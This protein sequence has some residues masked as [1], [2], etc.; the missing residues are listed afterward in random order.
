MRKSRSNLL[1]A[2]LLILCSTTLLFSEIPSTTLESFPPLKEIYHPVSTK[3]VEAQ[4]NFDRGLTFIY[5]FNHD[6]AY[7][8][9]A[10]AAEMD[11]ELAMAYW[12]MALALGQNINTDVTLE[13][14]LKAYDLVQKAVKLA[15]LASASEQSYIQALSKRYTNDSEAD[16]VLLRFHYRD[17]MKKVAAAYPE[18]LDATTLYAESIL[19]LDPWKYWNND[20]SP[21]EGTLEVVEKLESVLSRNPEHL[22]A[23][24]YYIHA[25]EGSLHPER[26]LPSALRLETLLPAAG[27]LLHMPCHIFV[28][29]GDYR[30]AVTMSKRAIEADREYMKTQGK[31]QE[32]SGHYPVHY[33]SHNYLVLTRVYMLLEEYFNAI[34]TASQLQQFL[35]PHF[36]TMPDRIP[37]TLVSLQVYLYFH[38]WQE[39]INYKT[40]SLTPATQA[41]EHYSRSSAFAHLHDM[42]AA[43]KER[44]LM[45]AAVL[46]IE[47]EEIAGNPAKKVVGLAEI[48]LEATFAEVENRY[49]ESIEHLQKALEV[50]KEL[51]YNEPPAWHVPIAQLLGFAY[52]HEKNYIEAEKQFRNCLTTLR[53]NGRSL[54]GLWKSLV[55]QGRE[56]DAY[57][58]ERE[59][60]AALGPITPTFNP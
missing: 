4:K 3:N 32:W 19:D 27:H 16:F 47:E 31:S 59:M 10:K 22:G 6:L 1:I 40:L 17:A 37:L 58:V 45:K 56:I 46:R 53:R 25:M 42:A 21:R 12:G 9:F 29:L 51:Y 60:K 23:N 43:R 50:E 20:G 30:D 5:A 26:A 8:Y 7:S 52:L 57:W 41:F 18:D 48:L 28:L 11:P 13:N 33:L 14:E 24:H 55:N 35:L 54:F 36:N 15:P 44:D 38:K 2:L 34:S 49:P 39:I